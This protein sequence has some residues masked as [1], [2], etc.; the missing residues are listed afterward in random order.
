[1][2]QYFLIASI[3]LNVK[4]AHC[5]GKHYKYKDDKEQHSLE[6]GRKHLLETVEAT[7][8]IRLDAE[9]KMFLINKNE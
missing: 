7:H 1:M 3:V 5:L 2:L 8:D 4:L 6:G 9:N